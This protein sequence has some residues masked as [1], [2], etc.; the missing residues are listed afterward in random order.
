ML[1]AI[2][3]LNAVFCRAAKEVCQFAFALTSKPQFAALKE[4]RNLWLIGWTRS[5]TVF[6]TKPRT[7]AQEATTT[8]C[9]RLFMFW[10]VMVEPRGDAYEVYVYIYFNALRV[11]GLVAM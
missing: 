11:A 1:A 4:A 3:M 2:R 6:Y 8:M 9:A 10:G 5:R 7:S